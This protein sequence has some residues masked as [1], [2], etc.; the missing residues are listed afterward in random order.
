[1]SLS[2]H[3]QQIVWKVYNYGEKMTAILSEGDAGVDYFKAW[4]GLNIFNSCWKQFISHWCICRCARPPEC[5]RGNCQM[6]WCRLMWHMWRHVS[7]SAS[8]DT[9]WHLNDG[10]VFVMLLQSNSSPKGKHKKVFNSKLNFFF[11]VKMQQGKKHKMFLD[12]EQFVLN[13]FK[14]KTTNSLVYTL[15]KKH[16]H[17]WKI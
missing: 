9:F 5:R 2:A 14:V 15:L 16:R 8:F 7:L 3:T 13:Y 17:C 4:R 12:F 1:M 6:S 10:Y 11:S